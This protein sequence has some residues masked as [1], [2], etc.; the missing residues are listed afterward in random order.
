MK[1]VSFS[2]RRNGKLIKESAAAMTGR[3]RIQ[4][5]AM[6][7]VKSALYLTLVTILLAGLCLMCTVSFNYGD[8][9]G[10]RSILLSTEKDALL[11]NGFSGEATAGEYEMLTDGSTYVGGGYSVVYYPEGVLSQDAYE[12]ELERRQALC[13]S[14]T[15]A[16]NEA[17]GD[18]LAKAQ[19]DLKDYEEN[20][21]KKGSLY[22]RVGAYDA[23]DA[24]KKG[25]CSLGEGNAVTF[26]EKFEAAFQA[27]V[28]QLQTRVTELGL[29]DARVEVRDT[30]SVSVFLPALMGTQGQGNVMTDLGTFGA[31]DLKYG[32]SED[33]ATGIAFDADKNE[34][35]RDY[36]K[37]AY[38]V[39]NGGTPSVAISFTKAGRE[40]VKN[41]TAEASGSTYLYFYVGDRSVITLTASQQ[42]DQSTLYI[43]GSYTAPWAKSAALAIDTALNGQATDLAFSVGEVYVQEALFGGLAFTLCCIACAVLFVAMLIGMFVRY[44]LL[45]FVYLY[46]LLIYL[47]PM[48]L[49]VWGI[50]VLHLGIETFLAVAFGALLLTASTAYTYEGARKEYAQG[51]TIVTSVKGS[52]KKCFWP[53]FDLH[54]VLALI[55]FVTYFI[56]MG[57]LAVFAF[58]MGLATVLSGLISLAVG[59]FDWACMMSF[60]KDKGKFCNFK[61]EELED[62]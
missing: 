4:E 11:G 9:K 1:K 8:F 59:R 55:S 45:G 24:E 37:S 36:V 42:I 28:C 14:L 53:V 13:D 15:A 57:E 34:T 49:L 20:Y 39:S 40:A 19:K 50:P 25:V 52:Y 46:S 18:E 47:F 41:W 21:A 31:F 23:E 33:S 30:Y 48:I 6:G 44:H 38:Y 62:E 51:K 32:S 5:E 58:T 35:I 27:A 43:S 29:E 12:S 16:G 61:R 60:A 7:K 22:F 2:A 54:I 17:D 3:R 26:D 56:A 10:F